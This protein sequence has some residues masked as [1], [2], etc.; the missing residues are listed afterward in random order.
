MASLRAMGIAIENAEKAVIDGISAVGSRLASV[1]PRLR[2]HR[3]CTWA[4][5]E[6]DGYR[7]DK[8]DRERPIKHDDHHMD[9][10]RY[11]VVGVE[12]LYRKDG[13]VVTRL[14]NQQAMLA[15]VAR[16]A[17]RHR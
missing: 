2:I 16:M 15:G 11:C 7:W 6:F 17:R 9:S 4:A 13:E 5:A 3:R 12:S 14:A 1:P 8:E 10:C